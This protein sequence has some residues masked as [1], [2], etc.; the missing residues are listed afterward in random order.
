VQRRDAGA[1]ESPLDAEVRV[2]ASV[3]HRNLVGFRGLY[4]D[5]GRQVAIVMELYVGWMPLLVASAR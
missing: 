5:G 1:S 4:D 3:K 2:L